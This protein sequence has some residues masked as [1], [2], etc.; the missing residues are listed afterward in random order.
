MTTK[1]IARFKAFD[2]VAVPFPYADRAAEKRRP[3]VVVSD[4]ALEREHGLL[5]LVMVTSADNPAWRGDIAIDD[6]AGAGLPHASVVRPAKLA[7]IDA[8]R[9]TPIGRLDNAARAK[10]AEALR[11][12]MATS[13]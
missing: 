8:A 1:P 11:R 5:W 9:A 6:L 13:R 3:A 4:P 12:T 7:T 10:L 2:V